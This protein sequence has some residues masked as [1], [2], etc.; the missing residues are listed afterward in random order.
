MTT[1]GRQ[2]GGARTFNRDYMKKLRPL[3]IP[4]CNNWV[5]D[6]SFQFSHNPSQGLGNFLITYYNG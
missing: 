3:L 4:P 6:R 2:S 1:L 5:D